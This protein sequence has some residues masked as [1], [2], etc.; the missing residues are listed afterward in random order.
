[1]DLEPRVGLNGERIGNDL[2]RAGGRRRFGP[3]R[4][5]SDRGLPTHAKDLAKV[6]NFHM[7]YSG[8]TTDARP[9]AIG[10]WVQVPHGDATVSGEPAFSVPSVRRHR[11]CGP[12]PA[13]SMQAP[14]E[15]E[16]AR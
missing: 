5:R 14:W 1:E 11:H 8:A 12:M 2:E 4:A 3:R 6:L 9:V 15:G 16:S 7:V 13:R 10:K